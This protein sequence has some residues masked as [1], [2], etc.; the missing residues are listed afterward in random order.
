MHQEQ[1]SNPGRKDD[2]ELGLGIGRGEG[3]LDEMEES[4]VK[5]DRPSPSSKET[6]GYIRFSFARMLLRAAG[7]ERSQ[8]WE[9][10]RK[11]KASGFRV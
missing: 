4:R 9:Q 11:A 10:S 5:K 3:G 8:S 1:M 2:A 6:G 7:S